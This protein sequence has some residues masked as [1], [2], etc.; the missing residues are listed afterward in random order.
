MGSLPGEAVSAPSY[1]MQGERDREGDTQTNPLDLAPFNV[2]H[3]ALIPYILQDFSATVCLHSK[4]HLIQAQ[5]PTTP[6]SGSSGAK[7]LQNGIW[8][9]IAPYS[10]ISSSSKQSASQCPFVSTL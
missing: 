3:F 1:P 2:H 4:E 10:D 6:I 5:M 9:K 8:L 7:N